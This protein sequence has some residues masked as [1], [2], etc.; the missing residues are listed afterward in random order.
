MKDVKTNKTNLTK[1]TRNYKRFARRTIR[2]IRRFMI[3]YCNV[4]FIIIIGFIFLSLAGM[5]TSFVDF[6]E[7]LIE[8]KNNIIVILV[9]SVIDLLIYLRYYNWMKVFK[10]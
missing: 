5:A 7:S 10:K 6:G 8:S 2:K 1:S 9:L 4:I 3:N